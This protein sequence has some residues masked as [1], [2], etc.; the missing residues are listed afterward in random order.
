ML[1][2]QQAAQYRRDGFTVYPGLLSGSDVELFLRA[3]ESIS[4]G[5]TLANHDKTRMEM[6][7]DQPPN[8]TRVQTPSNGRRSRVGCFAT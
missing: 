5:N 1:T 6:E 3:V 7:P 8:G 2:Q 4:E